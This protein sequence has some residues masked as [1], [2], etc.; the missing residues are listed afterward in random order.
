MIELGK[1]YKYYVDRYVNWFMLPLS[2]YDDEVISI[3]ARTFQPNVRLDFNSLSWF[4]EKMDSGLL[5]LS[6]SAPS[7]SDIP[8]SYK[9]KAVIFRTILRSKE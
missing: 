2:I 6:T 4:T 3:V 7:F 8:L 9:Q 5:T 1:W